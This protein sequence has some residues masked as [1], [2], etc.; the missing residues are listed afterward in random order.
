MLQYGMP[1]A[2]LT[3]GLSRVAKPTLAELVYQQ[4]LEAILSG[5]LQSG[6]YL[7]VPDVARENGVSPTPVRDALVRLSAEGLVEI[8]SNRRANR[9]PI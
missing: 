4:L 9:C 8:G 6:A 2:H 7:N 5:H 1:Q 3:K